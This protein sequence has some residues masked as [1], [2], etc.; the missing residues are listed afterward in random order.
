M[1]ASPGGLLF[2][3]AL[4]CAVSVV[5]GDRIQGGAA[6]SHVQREISVSVATNLPF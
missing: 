1:A 3:K 2:S 6:T 4:L 5:K